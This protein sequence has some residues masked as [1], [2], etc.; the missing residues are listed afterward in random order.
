M[1]VGTEAEPQGDAAYCFALSGF[2]SLFATTHS[3]L[4]QKFGHQFEIIVL[5]TSGLQL[6]CKNLCIAVLSYQNNF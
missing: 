3:R 2:L 1:A 4:G 6:L 5:V